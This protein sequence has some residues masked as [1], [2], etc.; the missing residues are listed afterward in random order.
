MYVAQIT[1]TVFRPSKLF[2]MVCLN[3]YDTV[4]LGVISS[5]SV[6]ALV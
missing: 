4:R 5:Q 3:F 6:I 1:S 2:V